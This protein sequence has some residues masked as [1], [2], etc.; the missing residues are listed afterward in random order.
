MQSRAVGRRSPILVVLVSLFFLAQFVFSPHAYANIGVSSFWSDFPLTGFCGDASGDYV[1][2]LQSYLQGDGY[3]PGA[4]DGEFGTNTYDAL[5][6]YQTDHHLSADG[7]AGQNT[8]EKMNSLLNYTGLSECAPPNVN[9]YFYE[10]YKGVAKPAYFS[11]R[12]TDA[13]WFDQIYYQ[14]VS[15]SLNANDLYRMEDGFHAV[16]PA[17]VCS[18]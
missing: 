11:Q 7:C 18:G 13:Y 5:F 9:V 12:L 10:Y 6:D 1:V 16:S 14:N 2:G 4:I 17:G 15:S 3:T 8:W